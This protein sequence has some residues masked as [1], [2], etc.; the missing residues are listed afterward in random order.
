ML[1]AIS[2]ISSVVISSVVIILAALAVYHVARELRKNPDLGRETI[3]EETSYDYQPCYQ[4]QCELTVTENRRHEMLV[5]VAIEV[6]C[7]NARDKAKEIAMT[8]NHDD[9]ATLLRQEVK[10]EDLQ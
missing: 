7:E 3:S 1:F 6:Y 8:E 10:E 4:C 9:I 5:D 2:G